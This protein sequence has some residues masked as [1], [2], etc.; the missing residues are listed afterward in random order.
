LLQQLLLLPGAIQLPQA[1]LDEQSH[2]QN[3]QHYAEDAGPPA[4]GGSS[5]VGSDHD[6]LIA[7]HA[8]RLSAPIM[9]IIK[10]LIVACLLGIVLSLASGLFYLVNDKGESKKM[11]KALSIRVGLSVLLFVLLLIAW[12]QG[13]IQ[14]HGIR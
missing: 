8:A 5:G 14:P 3:R 4:A 13:L 12:S 1:E 2:A 7:S 9:S 10:I 11:V 6:I